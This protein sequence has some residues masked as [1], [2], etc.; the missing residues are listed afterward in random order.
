MRTRTKEIKIRLTEDELT[1]L[2]EKVKRTGMNR[3]IY[4]RKIIEGAK[5]Y[6]RVPHDVW[7]L[8]IDLRRIGTDL[9]WLSN[10]ATWTRFPDA[11]KVKSAC[12]SLWKLVH[13]MM[14][15]FIDPETAVEVYEIRKMRKQERNRK[16]EQ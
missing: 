7:Q 6:E 10:M 13:V 9:N 1:R 5:V 15:E 12:D 3:E 2:N 14:Q 11:D 4:L 8:T 16:D